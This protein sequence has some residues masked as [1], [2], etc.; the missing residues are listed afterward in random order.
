M[1]CLRFL[2][3]PMQMKHGQDQQ[4]QPC[5]QAWVSLF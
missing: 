4:Q 5:W 2:N 1:D 3:S